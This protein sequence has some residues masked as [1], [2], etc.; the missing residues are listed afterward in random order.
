MLTIFSFFIHHLI[1]LGMELVSDILANQ[2]FRC[3]DAIKKDYWYI[4][5]FT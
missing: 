1:D 2:P 4:M 3:Q 5:D